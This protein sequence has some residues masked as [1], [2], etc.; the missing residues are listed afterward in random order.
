VDLVVRDDRDRRYVSL[1]VTLG[2]AGLA[3]MVLGGLAYEVGRSQPTEPLAAGPSAA[4]L[5]EPECAL[6]L[7]RVDAAVAAGLRLERALTEHA[8]A[9]DDLRARRTTREQA[10]SRAV[11]PLRGAAEDRRAFKDALSTYQGRRAACRE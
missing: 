6:A 2:A 11:P 3:A 10:L 7:D 4:V 5:E 8:R 9:I 1:L